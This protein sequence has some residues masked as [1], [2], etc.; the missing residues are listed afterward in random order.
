MSF[1]LKTAFDYSAAPPTSY[2]FRSYNI[3]EPPP[4]PNAQMGTQVYSKLQLKKQRWPVFHS[5]IALQ[6]SH[7]MTM[8]SN[9]DDGDA[10]KD[11]GLQNVVKFPRLGNFSL[12]E[13]DNVGMALALNQANALTHYQEAYK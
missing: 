9:V 1:R 10:K 13:L 7:H 12:N 5:S 6:N 8:V 3:F 4:N 2:P 11:Y